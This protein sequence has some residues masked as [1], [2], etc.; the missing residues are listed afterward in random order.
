MSLYNKVVWSQGLFLQPQHFQQHDRYLERY[1]ET[2]CAGL[3]THSWGF[4]ELQLESDLLNIGKF[5]LRRA[6]GVFPDGTPFRLPDDDPLPAPIE[7]DD[8]VRDQVVF[9]A[10][11]LR[12]PEATHADREADENSL[13]RYGVRDFNARD[14]NSSEGGAELVEVGALR[15]RLLLSR[16]V[17][18]AY[19]CIPVAHVVECHS[20]KRVTVDDQFMPTVLHVRAADRLATV[21][22]E[23]LG[24]LH[25]RGEALGG[26]TAAAG[27]GAA[28]EVADFLQLQVI[29]RYE[30]LLAHDAAG[31]VHPED[32][33]RLYLGAVGELAT[34]AT[35]SRRPPTLP[36]YRHDQLRDSFEPVVAVLREYLRQVIERVAVPIPLALKKY[37]IRVASVTDPTLYETAVFVLAAKADLP[38]EDVRQR[39]PALLKIGPGEKIRQL[40]NKALPGVTINPAPVP[41]R[42]IPLHTGFVYF[43]L[44]QSSALWGELRSSGGLAMHLSGEFPGL[45][46]ELWAIRR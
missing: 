4:T 26:M 36:A 27:R 16:D 6:A 2:R 37:G 30:C 45:A 44:D 24:L 14:V 9:L 33:F 7:I 43:E 12:R 41:P 38:T 39:F 17:T 40:V 20:D 29:N 5:G 25:Q 13:A 46:L 23:L 32:L 11:P 3:T 28:A 1:V 35:T 10:V 21:A 31:G 42:Q 18:D 8:D 19:A 34:F 15:T 22:S